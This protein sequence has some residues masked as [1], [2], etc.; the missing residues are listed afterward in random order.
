MS[1]D[2]S[3]EVVTVYVRL[4]DEGTDVW[5]PV[6]ARRLNG[7]NVLLLGKPEA[8]EIWEFPSGAAVVCERREFDDGAGE[9]AV[10][11]AS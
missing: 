3:Y 9:V 4:L 1:L 7:Q 11:L 6:Q 10:R 8:G 2:P 5:R